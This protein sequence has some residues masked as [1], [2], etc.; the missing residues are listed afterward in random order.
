MTLKSISTEYVP[1]ISSPSA[2]AAFTTAVKSCCSA[3]T[4]ATAR[5]KSPCVPTWRARTSSTKPASTSLPRAATTRSWSACGPMPPSRTCSRR[6]IISGRKKTCNR[7]SWIWAWNT[8]W[9]PTTPPWWCCVTKCSLNTVSIAATPSA[10]KSKNWPR[11]SVRLTPPPA[12]VR[13][14]PS[15]CTPATGRPIAA[16]VVEAVAPSVSERCCPSLSC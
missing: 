1:L 9:S 7:A 6:L 14:P 3:I 12:T 8:A 16:A 15:P 2:S 11:P 10:G 4:G 13:T 5:Q